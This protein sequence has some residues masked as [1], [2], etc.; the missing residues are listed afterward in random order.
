MLSLSLG[1]TE[2]LL[3]R[4]ARAKENAWKEVVIQVRNVL[5]NSLASQ[6]PVLLLMIIIF[7]LDNQLAAT[8]GVLL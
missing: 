3:H 2:N 5:T 6:I 8:T 7:I 1:C 4:D